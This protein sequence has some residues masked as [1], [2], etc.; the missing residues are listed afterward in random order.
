MAP[1]P[2]DV[3]VTEI[4]YTCPKCNQDQ[5]ETGEIRVAGGFWS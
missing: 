1:P 3:K 2:G 4:K 5:Y